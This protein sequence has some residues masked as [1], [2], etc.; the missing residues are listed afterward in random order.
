MVL[1]QDDD[2]LRI[3]QPTS[4]LRWP[5]LSEPS[6]LTALTIRNGLLKE[7][8]R[9]TQANGLSQSAFLIGARNARVEG[10]PIGLCPIRMHDYRPT[11][12][13]LCGKRQTLLFLLLHPRS[14]LVVNT[15]PL[16]PS[17]EPHSDILPYTDLCVPMLFVALGAPCIEIKVC[18]GRTDTSKQGKLAQE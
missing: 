5:F 11:R 6:S 17:T 13:L 7:P 16:G 10:H 12:Q 2:N 8:T 18:L 9:R 4:P 14:P 1:D 15:L 3:T